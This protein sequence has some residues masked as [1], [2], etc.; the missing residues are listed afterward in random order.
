[1]GE[2]RG[3]KKAASVD[4]ITSVSTEG[5]GFLEHQGPDTQQKAARVR[6]S[7][8]RGEA[9]PQAG[10]MLGGTDSAMVPSSNLV[11]IHPSE[12]QTLPVFILRPIQVR[13]WLPFPCLATEPMVRL[14]AVPAPDLPPRSGTGAVP[15]Q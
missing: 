3:G 7:L 5:G 9:G 11:M 12:T 6:W 13:V 15:L 2:S 4:K 1:M 10:G 8:H 14:F